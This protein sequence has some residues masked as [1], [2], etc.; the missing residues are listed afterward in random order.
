MVLAIQSSEYEALKLRTP[1]KLT[2]QHISVPL[3]L[4]FLIGFTNQTLFTV[5]NSTEAS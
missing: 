4:Q 2:S 5:S 1:V 3:V